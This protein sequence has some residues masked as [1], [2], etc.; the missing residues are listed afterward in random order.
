[1]LRALKRWKVRLRAS[2]SASPPYLSVLRDLLWRAACRLAV[3]VELVVRR[4][5][6]GRF[7][8]VPQLTESGCD[9]ELRVRT[10]PPVTSERFVPM[11]PGRCEN[12]VE[13]PAQ[14]RAGLLA[15]VAVV[16]TKSRVL[17]NRESE[18]TQ[19]RRQLAALV[20]RHE[21]V[22]DTVHDNDA[23]DARIHDVLYARRERQR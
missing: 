7:K 22:V 20:R 12:R 17:I 11:V 16:A 10:F 14:R 4:R 23:F 2:S 8:R 13:V 9:D 6:V 5:R 1:M 21:T 19:L 15:L 18:Q 3:D